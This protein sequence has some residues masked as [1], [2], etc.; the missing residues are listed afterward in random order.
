[1]YRKRYERLARHELRTGFTLIEMLVVLGIVTALLG[2]SWGIYQKL[3]TSLQ[4][5][6]AA[7]HVTSLLRAAR[8]F[9]RTSGLASRVLVDTSEGTVTALGYE[10]VAGY[11]F[12]DFVPAAEVDPPIAEG[13]EV[14]GAL[15]ERGRV[16]GEVHAVRGRIGTAL[17]F[18]NDG[19]AVVAAYVPRY[20]SPRGFSIEAWVLF[21]QPVLTEAERKRAAQLARR[22]GS[23]VDPRRDMLCAVLSLRD[24]YELGVLGDGAVYV[25]LGA[26]PGQEGSFFTAT[27]GGDVVPGRWTHLRATLDGGELA[28]EVDG[29]VRSTCPDGFE[30]IAE[31]QW[32]PVPKVVP[33][34]AGDL[35]VSRPD[36]IF[37]GAIDEPKFRV[38][39][40]PKIVH[41]PHGVRI[42]GRNRRI[43]FDGRGSLDPEHHVHPVMIR[44]EEESPDGARESDSRAGH[45]AVAAEP[46]EEEP[47]NDGETKLD[48]RDVAGV[49][50]ALHRYLER[51][52]ESSDRGLGGADAAPGAETSGESGGVMEIV[53]DLSGMIRS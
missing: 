27:A 53:V 10:L 42:L 13:T 44:L 22:K 37:L 51:N 34:P 18:A 45:T 11:H 2:L 30:G 36:R 39:L 48:E 7:S 6:A 43:W 4:L 12:E 40:P 46:Q 23:W 14:R 35:T 47:P 9:S 28:V 25:E 3:S 38:A 52:L 16:T 50:E 15:N 24:S 26:Y 31:A 49:L 20:H 17:R 8:N 29:M 33:T 1:M 21:E 19:A 32:P 41:L 5:P